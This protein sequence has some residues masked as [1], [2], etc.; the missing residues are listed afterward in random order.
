MHESDH[1]PPYRHDSFLRKLGVTVVTA[2]VLG[3]MTWVGMGM[4]RLIDS[5]HALHET[6]AINMLKIEQIQSSLQ[7]LP[8][9]TGEVARLR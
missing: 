3:V 1:P 7:P 4:Q 6:S 8:I 2:L 5:T 9:L